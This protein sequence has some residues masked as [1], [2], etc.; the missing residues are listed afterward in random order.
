MPLLGMS[1]A[2][3]PNESLIL[4]SL[5]FPHRSLSHSQKLWPP[6]SD[7]EVDPGLSLSTFPLEPSSGVWDPAFELGLGGHTHDC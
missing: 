3:A 5:S 7:S 2:S 1:L 4:F 6:A